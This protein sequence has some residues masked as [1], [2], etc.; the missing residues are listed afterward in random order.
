MSEPLIQV[1]LRMT[2]PQ[3]KTL[4]IHAAQHDMTLQAIYTEA[5]HD[6]AEKHGVELA[7][8]GDDA[9]DDEPDK[10]A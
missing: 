5:L 9:D 4:K 3:L 2:R 6:W 8:G 7:E 1:A 10:V